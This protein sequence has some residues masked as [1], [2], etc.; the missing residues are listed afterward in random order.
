MIIRS[1]LPYQSA[2]IYADRGMAKWTGFFIS[3][4]ATALAKEGDTV[5]FT[6]AMDDEEKMFLLSQ[7]YLNQKKVLLYTTLRLQ[8]YLGKIYDMTKDKLY[9]NAEEKTLHFSYSQILKATLAEV[10]EDE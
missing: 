3:E 7:V 5:E 10:I 4:H 8:P 1:Y 9:L 2:K 6:T